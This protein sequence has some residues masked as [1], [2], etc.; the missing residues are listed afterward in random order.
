MLQAHVGM[1][2]NDPLQ[3]VQLVAEPEHYEHGKVQVEQV[4]VLDEK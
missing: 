3:T 4:L 1:V 2:L